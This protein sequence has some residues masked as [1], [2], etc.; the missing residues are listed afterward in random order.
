[1]AAA[2]Q[3]PVAAA[4]SGQRLSAKTLRRVQAKIGVQH[5][6]AAW[7]QG[8]TH[9]LDARVVY[10][11]GSHRHLV[12]D[13][14]GGWKG[15]WSWSWVEAPVHRVSCPKPEAEVEVAGGRL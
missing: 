10:P 14:H 4:V 6:E 5:L 3:L 8:G 1:M 11:D 9:R 12:I 13:R 7:A 2:A 15:D